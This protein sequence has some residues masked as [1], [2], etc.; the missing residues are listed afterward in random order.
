MILLLISDPY[1]FTITFLTT[2]TT[3][4]KHIMNDSE[5]INQQRKKKK[6]KET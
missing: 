4:S 5:L 2:I 1:L 6:K 3:R